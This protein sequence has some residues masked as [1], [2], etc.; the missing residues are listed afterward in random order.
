MTLTHLWNL[1]RL[2]LVTHLIFF[3]NSYTVEQKINEI[4][5]DQSTIK[6]FAETGQKRRLHIH[7]S[8]QLGRHGN[9]GTIYIYIYINV[10]AV[11]Q[12]KKYADACVHT[13]FFVQLHLVFF[14][15]FQRNKK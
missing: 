13:S 14:T 5:E 4:A 8:T 6:V 7:I 9:H 2:T 10:F 3:V 1:T 15:N 12:S 11:Q